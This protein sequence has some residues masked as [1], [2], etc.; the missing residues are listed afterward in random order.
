MNRAAPSRPSPAL[1]YLALAALGLQLL[2]GVAA[3]G[4]AA[5]SPTH[6]HVSLDGRIHAHV[7]AWEHAP[8]SDAAGP[9]QTEA[10]P[11]NEGGIT[12]AVALPAALALVAIAGALVLARVPAVSG[13]RAIPSLPATPPPRG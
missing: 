8:A 11:A 2:L 6:S 7:H 3:P 12:T 10:A 5:W 13:Y 4:F 9:S 1:A